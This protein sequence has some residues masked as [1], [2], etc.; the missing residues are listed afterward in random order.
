MKIVELSEKDALYYC[1]RDEDH[2]FDRKAFGIKGAKI[3]K[4]AVAFAN[5]DGGE[6]V[7]GID[8][9]SVSSDMPL[10]RW[11]GR[12]ST[13]QFNGMIQALSELSPS[14]DFRFDFLKAS[15]VQRSYVLRVQ[16]NKG[17]QVHKTT[18]DEVYVRKG[19][20]SILLK[21]PI[22]ILELTHAK[23][24]TSEEDSLVT[25]SSINDLESSN[26]LAEFLAQL[27]LTEPDPLNF[28]LQENLV[29]PSS[30][31][32]RVAA[33]LLFFENPCAILPKQCGLRIVRYDS[34]QDDIDRDALTEDNYL[35]EGPIYKQ[36][37][38]AFRTIKSVLS[39]IT[40]WT[41]DGL[42]SPEYP[43]EAIWEILVNTAIHRD[44]SISDNVLVSIFR[45]RVE[46]KSPGR[47]PGFVTTSNILD[48][49][50]SRNSK[51]VRLLSKY[52][53]SPNRDL[54]EGMNT[55]FQKMKD[56]G[57]KPPEVIEDGNF[58]RVTLKHVSIDNADGLIIEFLKKHN[59]I[60]NRQALDL[61]GLESPDKVTA[62]FS[63][64]RDRG[65]IKRNEATTGAKSQWELCSVR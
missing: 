56:A 29:D 33:I 9:E 32:P 4:I 31:T 24:I 13:E 5:A 60:N 53:N 21:A 45:N 2:F 54:G 36:I 27:P 18:A 26:Y 7:V 3:Q 64:M 41:I 12:D 61:L 20:Q 44:Y 40:T 47:L 16:V 22:K 52:S 50:F 30:W 43:D 1:E 8:D 46:F 15:S 28:I 23:G 37:N 48:N 49:R 55:A 19:A 6:F 42:K 39:K 35:I 51:L 65:L 38:E 57:L 34:S 17:L 59:R 14:V 62:I 25:A 63:K 58:V 11:N 10:K